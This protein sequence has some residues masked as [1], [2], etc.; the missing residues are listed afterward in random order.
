MTRDELVKVFKLIVLKCD[1]LINNANYK[2][3]DYTQENVE[4]IAELCNHIIDGDFGK[5][6]ETKDVDLDV[7]LSKWRHS[8][9]H[10]RRDKDASGEYLERVSQLELAKHFYELG[11]KDPCKDCPHPKLNCSNFPCIEK[12]AFEQGKSVFE[13]IKTE[14]EQKPN[15]K[16][17]PKSIIER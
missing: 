11:K 8:H 12:R 17:E 13:C 5:L 10:G 16:V 4:D 3:D 6:V 2:A 14:H 9:F 15:D 7:E 1:M